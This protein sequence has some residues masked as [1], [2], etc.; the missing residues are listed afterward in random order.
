MG[1]S[2]SSAGLHSTTE[3]SYTSPLEIGAIADTNRHLHDFYCYILGFSHKRGF[4]VIRKQQLAVCC[5]I[6]IYLF[7]LAL[8]QY[9]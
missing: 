8:R 7:F 3:G 2:C 9:I 5:F 4:L 1:W 6:E